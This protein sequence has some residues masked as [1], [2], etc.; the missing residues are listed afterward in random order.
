MAK[1]YG[2][3]PSTVINKVSM[4][5][6]IKIY[7]LEW[8]CHNLHYISAEQGFG[9]LSILDLNCSQQPAKLNK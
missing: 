1:K 3:L 5:Y 6:L 9:M 4:H 8:F 7:L 2:S